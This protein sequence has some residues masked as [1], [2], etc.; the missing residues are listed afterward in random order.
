MV[1]TVTEVFSVCPASSLEVS[2]NLL[3]NWTNRLVCLLQGESSEDGREATEWTW[4]LRIPDALMVFHGGLA[5]IPTGKIE[6]HRGGYTGQPYRSWPSLLH[7]C[8]CAWLSRTGC[9]SPDWFVDP[10]LFFMLP[11]KVIECFQRSPSINE[12]KSNQVSL[13]FKVLCDLV[14]LVVHPLLYDSSQRACSRAASEHIVLSAPA[15]ADSLSPSLHPVPLFTPPLPHLTPPL[16]FQSFSSV[17]P[18]LATLGLQPFGV[19]ARLSTVPP[20]FVFSGLTGAPL[21]CSLSLLVCQ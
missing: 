21:F 15:P 17:K 1:E 20:V 8:G 6:A 10:G 7:L 4:L 14:L 13:A 3:G 19:P 2:L 16:Q 18:F 9:S 12:S 11:S 5:F